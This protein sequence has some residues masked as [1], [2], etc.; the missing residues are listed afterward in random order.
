MSIISTPNGVAS[1]SQFQIVIWTLM[2]GSGMIYVMMLTGNLIDVPLPTLALLGVTGFA[3]VG[4]K[5]QAGADNTPQRA[6]A[7]G[8]IGH[9]AVS[10]NPIDS[11]IV[12]KWE[13]PTGTDQPFSYTV[14]MRLAG[15]GA[16]STGARDV[17]GPPY[18]VTG[19]TAATRYNFKVF[20][21]NAAGAGPASIMVEATTAAVIGV[22]QGAPGQVTGLTSANPTAS[23][24]ELRWAVL[25]PAPTAHTVQYRPAGTLPWVTH[26][27]TANPPV[28]VTGLDSGT[29][30]AVATSPRRS[31]YSRESKASSPTSMPRWR[32]RSAGR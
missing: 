10:G 4:S 9:L 32:S 12:L 27:N 11:T 29:D 5:I 30:Y 14:Q 21:V 13:P 20:A 31:I 23:S 3:L 8:T 22:V 6:S 26:S 15:A 2:I 7:P 28:V 1:L 19:L 25:N 24:I 16:W 17:A 18:A